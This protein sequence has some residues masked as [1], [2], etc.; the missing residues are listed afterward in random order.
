MCAAPGRLP[1]ILYG[2]P[3]G[4]GVMGW[5]LLH[6]FNAMVRTYRRKAGYRRRTYRRR[7][8]TYRRK[9]QVRSRYGRRRGRRGQKIVRRR[10]PARNP[11]G[12]RVQVKFK[13]SRGGEMLSNSAVQYVRT[14]GTLNDLSGVITNIGSCPGFTIYPQLF[15]NYRVTGMKVTLTPMIDPDSS[16]NVPEPMTAYIN[17]GNGLLASPDV[18]SIPEQRWARYKNINCWLSGGSNRTV[19][20]YLS[21]YKLAGADR[22]VASDVDYTGTTLTTSPWYTAP[23]KGVSYEYG[24]VSASGSNWQTPTGDRLCTFQVNITWYVTFWGRRNLV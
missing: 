2:N 23:A 22:T 9:V 10:Y 7:R 4:H 18:G 8:V 1:V 5:P 11:F 12:D 14:S 6:V 13:F 16:V 3:L 17:G 15:N 19:A 24:I 20:N 21:V